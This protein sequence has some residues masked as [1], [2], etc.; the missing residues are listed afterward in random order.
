MR[1]RYII[2]LVL[3]L[4]SALAVAGGTLASSGNGYAV[5]WW[6]V[7]GGGGTSSGNDYT[8]SGAIGQPD[9]GSMS[10]GDYALTGGFWA[11]MF[12]GSYCVYLPLVL[13]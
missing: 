7:D 6:T 11:Q 12:E 4:T 10:G 2:L 9:A 1:K 3:V 8:V 5:T 13:R